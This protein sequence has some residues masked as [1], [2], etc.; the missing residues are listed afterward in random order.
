MDRSIVREWSPSGRVVTILNIAGIA[1]LI[2]AL[3]AYTGIWAAARDATGATITMGD[4]LLAMLATIGLMLLH[5]GI[6]GI[7]IA[8]F[9]G[10]PEFGATMVGRAL[11]ALYC[12]SAGTRFSRGQFIAIALAPAFV[13]GV[14]SAVAIAFLPG[15]GWLVVPAAFHLAGCVGDVAMVAI[16]ARL[17]RGARIEDRKSGMRIHIS[18]DLDASPA[19]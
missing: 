9:G 7:A 2:A 4:V 8:A 6:H 11:P 19:R 17:P 16:A 13:L 5:E 1:L 3:V 15:S 18:N 14:G 12:T 10:R